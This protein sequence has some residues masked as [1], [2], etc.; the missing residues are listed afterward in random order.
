[1]IKGS[2]L[3][4]FMNFYP[5]FIGAGV[6][7]RHI[8]KDFRQIDVEMKLRFWNRNYV[9]T[10][11]GGSLYSMCDPFYMLML[12]QNLGKDYI[13]WDK[14][15]SIKFIKPGRGNVKARFL[16]TEE[17]INNIKKELEEKGKIEPVFEVQVLD[18]NLQ[19]ICE[20]KKVIYIKKK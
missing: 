6:R 15:A 16:L 5:P 13:I 10:H 18:D 7:I 14:A 11:F 3:V 8:S 20:I 19:L 2:T 1:M 4:R 17:V 12:I 9:K